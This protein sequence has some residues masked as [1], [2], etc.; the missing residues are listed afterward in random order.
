[1]RWLYFLAL[2]LV[3]GSLGFRLICL[4]G[5]ALPP[6]RREAAATSLAGDRRRR[7]ARARDPRVLPPLRGRAP[8]AVREVPLRRPVADLGRHALR[9]G[10]RRD[11]ARRSRSSRRSSTSRGCSSGRGCSCLR[12]RSRSASPAGSRSRDTTRSIPGRRGRRELADWVHLSAASLWIGGLVALV[13]A[14]GRSAP[15]LR[16][17]AFVRFSRLATVLVALVLAAG[18][19]S[20][21][22]GCP[23]F[24][25]LWTQSYGQVLLVKLALVA[26]VL[27]WGGVHHFFVAAGARGRRRRVPRARRAER[28]GRERGRRSRCCSSRRCSSTRS[29]RRAVGPSR[30]LAAS[31][32]AAYAGAVGSSSWRK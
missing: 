24:H 25:D 8:A 32:C 5:L 23:H 12:S 18:T 11:D 4:R 2:A 14:S 16:R 9:Q 13:V 3:I 27:A 17:E 15:A 26:L 20:R 28:R 22:C 31:R 7:R 10:V 6:A 21:S 29:R 19:T 30:R 1:M